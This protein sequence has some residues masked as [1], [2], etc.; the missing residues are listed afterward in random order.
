VLVVLCPAGTNRKRRGAFIK[1][2][3]HARLRIKHIKCYRGGPKGKAWGK[4]RAA[5]V[6]KRE[7]LDYSAWLDAQKYGVPDDA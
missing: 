3:R 7:P 5:V 2:G 6:T 1:L 4:R